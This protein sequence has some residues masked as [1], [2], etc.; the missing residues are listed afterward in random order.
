MT[1]GI[2]API[3]PPAEQEWCE[4]CACGRR[5]DGDGPRCWVCKEPEGIQKTIR[6]TEAIQ[7]ASVELHEPEP[8][9]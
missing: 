4:E 7:A 3:D 6:A 5:V 8:S 9:K 1:P 2:E